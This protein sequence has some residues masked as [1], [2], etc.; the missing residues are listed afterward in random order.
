MHKISLSAPILHIH[1]TDKCEDK[2][3]RHFA[4]LWRPSENI[5]QAKQKKFK[6]TLEKKFFVCYTIT[7]I[8]K[9][10]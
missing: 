6:K 10:L 4:V 3:T 7:C 2:H 8:M 5:F 9:T 1:D